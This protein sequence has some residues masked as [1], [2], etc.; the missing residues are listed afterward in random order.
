MKSLLLAFV[1]ALGSSAC[2]QSPIVYVPEGQPV[3]LRETIPNA[4]VWVM[5]EKGEWIP[6]V[7]DL[8]AGWFALPDQPY[9][10]EP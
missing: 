7:I 8:P 4:Q 3:Q 10:V 9:A 1:I 2:K 5:T 6:G